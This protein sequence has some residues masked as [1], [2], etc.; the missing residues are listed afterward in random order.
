MKTAVLFWLGCSVLFLS[1]AKAEETLVV[2]NGDDKNGGA[3]W[4]GP[5]SDAVSIKPQELVGRN[6]SSALVLSGEGEGWIGFGWNWHA[7]FP[8]DAGTDVSSY[9]SLVFWIRLE[10]QQ[11][12]SLKV[13]LSS[14][15]SENPSKE[16]AF[17]HHALDIGNGQWQEII[18][19][20]TDFEWDST[21][22]TRK[23]W[24]LD[25]TTWSGSPRSFR[26]L[27][28]EIGFRK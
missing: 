11:P 3:G 25:I 12:E 7:W 14:S 16:V 21:F 1:I 2:W 28:D 20:F 19:P 27:V 5:Q 6:N 22:D 15:S 4:S 26:L 17:R 13:R 24:G 10:G 8:K 18:I 9:R 23:I